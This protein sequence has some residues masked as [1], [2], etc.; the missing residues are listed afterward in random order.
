MSN[1][2]KTSKGVTV[3]KTES[4]KVKTGSDAA[5]TVI[6]PSD[7]KS[8]R[9]KVGMPIKTLCYTAVFVALSAVANIF[10]WYPAG[11]TFALSLTYIPNFFAGALLGPFAGFTSGLLGDLIGCWIAPKGD[12]NPIILL[13]SGLMGL[14]PGIIF[15]LFKNNRS[16][17]ADYAAAAISLLL[18]FGICSTVNTIGLYVFYFRGAGKTLAAVFILRTPKQALIWAINAVIAVLLLYPAKKIVLK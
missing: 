3:G 14:I 13:A 12:L 17:A 2:L 18:I 10:T 11:S 6:S 1:K 5:V 7:T 8:G 16:K 4:A 15:R 9:K